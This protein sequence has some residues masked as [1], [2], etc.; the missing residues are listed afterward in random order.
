MEFARQEIDSLE[1]SGVLC[2]IQ[3]VQGEFVSNVFLHPK[4]EE[5]RYRMILNLKKLND[6]VEYHHFKMDTLETVLTLIRPGMFMASI[7]FTDVYYS[8]AIAEQDRKYLRFEFKNVLYEFTCLPNGL[9][10]GPRVFTM[11]LMV[12]LV[13]SLESRSL[14]T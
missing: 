11:I 8:W 2:K 9:S 13:S 10:S 5:G 1:V 4:K 14:V 3:H 7:D 12:P 6:F